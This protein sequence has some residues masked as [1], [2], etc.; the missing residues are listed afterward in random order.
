MWLH[1][2]AHGCFQVAQLWTLAR[3]VPWGVVVNVLHVRYADCQGMH[4]FTISIMSTALKHAA[5]ADI[6]IGAMGECRPSTCMNDPTG[7]GINR[8]YDKGLMLCPSIAGESACMILQH[9][10][11]AVLRIVA[12]TALET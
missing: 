12:A 2:H 10:L 8:S 3:A 11:D 5:V 6:D 7:V 1:A 9:H 4:Q